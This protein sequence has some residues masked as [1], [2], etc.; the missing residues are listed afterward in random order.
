M[1]FRTKNG[2]REQR[3]LFAVPDRESQTSQN[4]GGSGKPAKTQTDSRTDVTHDNRLKRSNRDQFIRRISKFETREN[5]G[6]EDALGAT[7]W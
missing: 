5:F 6:L 2:N 4:Q 1:G 7:G 3:L